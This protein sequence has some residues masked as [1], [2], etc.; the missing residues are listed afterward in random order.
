MADRHMIETGALTRDAGAGTRN[1]TDDDTLNTD[2]GALTPPNPDRTTV[3]EGRALLTP[4]GGDRSGE[5]GD[6]AV[7]AQRYR[8]RLPYDAALPLVG[9][10]WTS[11]AS[12]DARMVGRPLR[13]VDVLGHSGLVARESIVEDREP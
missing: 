7:T 12:L 2:T 11:S 4:E 10:L 6:R 13:V 1:D 9:D 5:E 3:Y 8:L